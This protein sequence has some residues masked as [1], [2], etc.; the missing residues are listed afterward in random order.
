MLKT[1]RFGYLTHLHSPQYSGVSTANCDAIS[2]KQ[3]RELAEQKDDTR[4]GR[5]APIAVFAT[6][7]WNSKRKRAGRQML[8]SSGRVP[9][10]LA[11]TLNPHSF[12]ENSIVITDHPGLIPSIVIWDGLGAVAQSSGYGFRESFQ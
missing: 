2:N 4:L 9:V 10:H 6:V 12:A 1:Y 7:S 8:A 5:P 11:S 3:S